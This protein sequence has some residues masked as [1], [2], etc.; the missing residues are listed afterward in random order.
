MQNE[1]EGPLST[2]AG[3]WKLA[4][5]G[6]R[7][8]LFFSVIKAFRERASYFLLRKRLLTVLEIKNISLCV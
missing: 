2:I 3:K 7:L 6:S 5:Q 1:L 8:P 4:Q